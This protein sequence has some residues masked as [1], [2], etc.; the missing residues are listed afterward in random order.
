MLVFYSYIPSTNKTVNF[1]LFV[2][3]FLSLQARS[4]TCKKIQITCNK[5]SGKVKM[6]TL[7]CDIGTKSASYGNCRRGNK[8]ILV[9]LYNL[10]ILL[11]LPYIVKQVRFFVC[12]FDI[13]A[14][15]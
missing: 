12:L 9:L 15:T 14:D 1:Y 5:C 13:Y 6:A 4:C 2:V 10:C 3:T 8:V 7:N 11:V